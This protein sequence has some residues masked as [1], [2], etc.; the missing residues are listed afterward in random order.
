MPLAPLR[1]AVLCSPA[2]LALLLGASCA[3]APAGAAGAPAPGT[4][5]EAVP[6]PAR[7]TAATHDG[8]LAAYAGHPF[9]V[10]PLQRVTTE[11]EL[12]APDS[13]RAVFDRALAAAVKSRGVGGGWAL[14][15]DLERS[16]RRNAG[17]VSD[18]HALSVAGLA[19]VRVGDP[20]SGTIAGELRGAVALHDARVALVPYAMRVGPRTSV[21]ISV[22]DA[23][24]ARVLWRGEVAVDAATAGAGPTVE[25]AADR[26][27][28]LFVA[29]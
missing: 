2:A 15:A 9:V 13:L 27:A 25:A 7:A 29:K 12:A 1:R 20:V 24:L 17:Y 19:A 10:Y 18:P 6:T 14:A 5:A 11:S 16:A 21:S 4:A 8:E 28:S 26:V 23:R 22:V 3:T